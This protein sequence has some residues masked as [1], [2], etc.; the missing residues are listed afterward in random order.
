MQN[1]SFSAKSVNGTEYSIT[2][3][4]L[5]FC[6]LAFPFIMLYAGM[7]RFFTLEF[8]DRRAEL[9]DQA[10]KQLLKFG[11]YAE[12]E[13][14]FH[15]LLQKKIASSHVSNNITQQLKK[16]RDELQKAYPNIFTFMFWDKK[17]NPINFLS[18]ET[19]FSFLAKKLNIF[20][21]TIKKETTA[22]KHS[23]TGFSE[24]HDRELRMMRQFLGPFVTVEELTA[25]FLNDSSARCFQMHARGDRALGWY[26]SDSEFSVLVFIAASGRGKLAG[27]T[28]LNRQLAGKIAGVQFFLLDEKEQ[29]ITPPIS[30]NLQSRLLINFGKFRQLAAAEQLESEGDY[31]NFQKLNQRWWA[32]AVMKKEAIETGSFNAG[33]FFALLVIALILVSFVLYCYFLVHEN[34]LH[35]VKTRLILIFAYIVFIPSLIFTVIGLD[36]LKQKES[37]I[38]ADNAVQAFQTL[39]SIDNQFKSF[40]YDK[41]T[42]L[43]QTLDDIFRGIGSLDEN[44]LAS[45]AALVQKKFAPDT[46]IVTD[47]TGKDILKGAYTVT[48]KD[49]FLRKTAAGE[50]INYLNSR[51]D[52]LYNPN[53]SVASGFALSFINNY[54]R[55]MLFALNNNTF[56]SY[57]N[58]LREP[59][60]KRFTN[61][62]QVFWQEKQV[63][64][65][66]LKMIVDTAEVENGKRLLFWLPDS[67]K[68]YPQIAEIQALQPFFAKV[69]Q[70]GTSQQM[71]SSENG[72]TF[73]AFGQAG[74]NLSSAVMAIL[75]DG[76]EIQK[77]MDKLR[78]SILLLAG[79]GLVMTLSLFSLLR[80]YLIAPINALATGVEMVKNRNYSFRVEL[81]FDNEFGKLGESIDKTLENLQDLEIAQTVQESLLPQEQLDFGNFQVLAR[82]R[83]MTSMGGDYYDY[84]I[85]G[86][87]NL[88]ILMADV[89]GHG[90][91]AALLMAMAKSVLLM[92]NTGVV[93][94]ADVMEGLNKTFCTLR[95]AEISTMMTGQIIHIASDNSLSFFNGG[96]CP[97]LT[98]SRNGDTVTPLINQSLPFGFLARRNFSGVSAI[99]NP[100]ETMILYS[101]GILECLDKNEETLGVTGFNDLIINS[102][103]QDLE[104][105]I[106]NLFKGYEKWAASQQDDIT[107]VLIRRKEN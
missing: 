63:H 104:V 18:D 62:I 75:M 17:G 82:T 106:S 67:G 55:L 85:D 43:N 95:K 20:L 60:T 24:K 3:A 81:P 87:N 61:L 91:Q 11:E 5:Y 92:K 21:N 59:E 35:S 100:G 37:Q 36:F 7:E 71:I 33:H 66:Y 29:K 58:T 28:Y 78:H 96:H 9:F 105:F 97:P 8:S 64:Y 89:A 102:H 68:A 19:R 52:K 6:L 88:T 98:V 25:P 42:A 22:G 69:G 34:P 48:I 30:E 44:L 70:N 53:Q 73:L 31:Y 50:L 49:D 57:L 99:L 26:H 23:E 41:G 77:Q 4:A 65:D 79:L 80:Y 47:D 74:T 83:A 14:F 94:P 39:T 101:D 1:M 54:R 107:F 38:V 15:L 93:N 12:D 76:S 72:Q 90:V 45:A 84:V 46:F 10:G 86:A 32:A 27:P 13:R 2:R 40:L 16:K 56:F 51:A 103:H